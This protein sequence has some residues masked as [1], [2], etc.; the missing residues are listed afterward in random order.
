MTKK[1]AKKPAPASKSTAV[2][3]PLCGKPTRQATAK[4]PTCHRPAGWGTDHPGQGPCK[5]HG[6]ASPIKSGRYSKII[7]PRLAEL[8]AQHEADPDPLNIL[9]EL[10]A[11]RALF[12]DFIERYDEWREAVLA[13]YASWS[14]Y[15][16]PIPE[17]LA[18]AFSNAID[19]YEIMVREDGKELTEKQ[20]AGLKEARGLVKFLK[21]EDA[22]ARPREILDVSAAIQHINTISMIVKRE[23]DARAD[24]AISRKDLMRV[25]QEMAGSVRKH[26]AVAIPDEERLIET[27][28]AIRADW[29]EIR[30]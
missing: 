23:Q 12:V 20:V 10:A 21:G 25:Q 11:A 15:K 9:P 7:R 29:V 18:L 19:E 27:L 28:K 5:L 24:N 8:I 30:V 4:Y 3:K 6:G 22:P 13:W 1:R 14:A 16:R 17:D 26:L 2:A